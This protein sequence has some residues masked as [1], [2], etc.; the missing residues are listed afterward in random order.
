MAFGFFEN[1]SQLTLSKLV[2]NKEI[3]LGFDDRL[4]QS[5]LSGFAARRLIASGF[6]FKHKK[7]QTILF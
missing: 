4:T 7:L 5:I 3:A 2:S 1:L 6:V